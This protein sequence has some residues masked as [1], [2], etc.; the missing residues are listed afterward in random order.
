[1]RV[2]A[3]RE[4]GMELREQ[5]VLFR[6]GHDS[7]LLELELARRGIPFVKY[8]GLRYLD[9]AH[10]KDLLALARLATNPADE[11]SWFR[12]LQLLDG[13]GPVRAR[14]L[15]DSL[16][17]ASRGAPAIERWA[18]AAAH[19]PAHSREHAA[20]LVEAL[21]AAASARDASAGPCIERLCAA[22]G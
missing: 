22:L 11:V 16:R 3:A 9:A 8:G 7:A 12:V 2:L 4:E 19:V 18:Q 15:L 5:A 14:R 20:A 21:G 13:V 17:P 6:T 10:V 1:E